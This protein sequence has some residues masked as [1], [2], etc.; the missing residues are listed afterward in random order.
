MMSRQARSQSKLF[1]TGLNLDK[2][3]RS[4][5]PLRKIH[6]AIYFDFIYDEV[7]HLYGANGNPSV[8][9]VVILKLMLLLVFYD[10][11]SERE[12][13]DTVPERMDWLWFLGFDL[14]TPIPDH[15]VL[16]KARKRWG[17]DVFRN[18]FERIVF[19]CVEAGLVDGSK[20]FMDASIVEADASMESVVDV[21]S[22]KHRLHQSY[23]EFERRLEELEE[24]DRPNHKK[25]NNK[26]VST[27]DSDAAITR[28]GGAKLAYKIHRGVDGANE[29]I[30]ATRTTPGD[31]HESH[32]L[33]AL[34]DDHEAN[35]EESVET[36]VADAQYGTVDILLKCHDRGVRTH[37]PH[38]GQAAQ[39]RNAVRGVFGED[40][41]TYDA[42]SDVLVCPA[43]H[44]LKPRGLDRLNDAI[45]YGARKS[46]CDVCELRPRCTKN[47]TGRTVI[48]RRRQEALDQKRGEGRSRKGKI[49]I[50]T[51]QHLMERSFARAK[52]YSFDRSRWRGL[53]RMEIQELLTCAVQNIQVL[54]NKARQRPTAEANRQRTRNG[55]FLTSIWLFRLIFT[56][57]KATLCQLQPIKR[58]MLALGIV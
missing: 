44:E 34:I 40:S 21:G 48:R 4:N 3:V 15:S 30:T 32:L 50:R 36:V 58:C 43:G 29:I 28:D 5:H 31:T 49:D 6:K 7:G 16:S 14:D 52:R 35:T 8:A 18:F 9:P 23:P 20:L 1:Y 51:R 41:F 54:V 53:W 10:V 24:A 57:H 39:K 12:L 11:R 33:E 38:L 55:G 13:M 17:V 25:V 42:T 27:T 22:I 46:D 56:D 45:R 2:R 19:Q 37:M 47:K 26:R